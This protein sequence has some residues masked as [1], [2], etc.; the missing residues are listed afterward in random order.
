MNIQATCIFQVMILCTVV[1]GLLVESAK[2]MNTTL[3]QTM[4]AAHV[5]DILYNI[6]GSCHV[7]TSS[8]ITTPELVDQ[9]K[10]SQY[11]LSSELPFPFCE[12]EAIS[13]SSKSSIYS[14]PTIVKSVPVVSESAPSTSAETKTSDFK[15]MII[16]GASIERVNSEDSSLPDT[17]ASSVYFGETSK[18]PS[19]SWACYKNKKDNEE[20]KKE[21]LRFLLE[22]FDRGAGRENAKHRASA[23]TTLDAFENL[24]SSTWKEKLLLTIPRIKAFFNMNEGARNKMR[25]AVA[26]YFAS[27]NSHPTSTGSLNGKAPTEVTEIEL[28]HVQ[29]AL[30]ESAE[31]IER[32]ATLEELVRDNEGLEDESN[33]IM[34]VE[35]G[36]EDE[37]QSDSDEEENEERVIPAIA[38]PRISNP[39]TNPYSKPHYSTSASRRKV[40]SKYTAGEEVSALFSDDSKWYDV[41]ITE[42][43]Y[44]VE[45]STF[46]YKVY[47]SAD[48]TYWTV[49]EE[50][51]CK[52]I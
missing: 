40:C 9:M 13:I 20:L 2:T 32:D 42:V 33:A 46:K 10:L 26:K 25:T 22:E 47:C 12:V 28:Q 44:L 24:S 11:K 30:I 17:C 15:K 1:H 35:L 5:T 29:N 38:P 37:T 27:E 51:I 8:D 45:S 21:T 7:F 6:D 23:W 4:F 31:E 48:G 19:L 16:S 34:E 18:V 3:R 41:T 52:N 49:Q 14:I 50:D 36:R 43:K 39:S